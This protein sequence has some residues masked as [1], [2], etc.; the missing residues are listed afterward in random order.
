MPLRLAINISGRVLSDLSITR[1]VLRTTA[2]AGIDP[3]QLVLE[4]TEGVLIEGGSS[5]IQELHRLSDSGIDL[6]I[7]DFGTG[8]SSLSYLQRFPV[9]TVKIDRSFVAGLG[10]NRHDTAIVEA[11]I[12]LCRTLGLTTIAEGV[13]TP[14]Q[15]AT[16]RALGCTQA[17]GFLLGRPVPPEQLVPALPTRPTPALR[18]PGTEVLV[19]GPD[20][21]VADMARPPVKVGPGPA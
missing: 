4:L 12:A 5:V 9:E 3:S 1:R 14:E 17:Q 15:L 16:L 10:V 7:D 8:Y 21:P 13:E 6:A 19:L 2:R 18:T 20:A 11:V